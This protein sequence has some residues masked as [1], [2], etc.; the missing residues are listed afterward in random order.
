MQ[1]NINNTKFQILN[2]MHGITLDNV[3][4]GRDLGVTIDNDKHTAT[5][6]KKAHQILDL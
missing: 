2:T 5:V 4:D 6:S 1:V 3:Q